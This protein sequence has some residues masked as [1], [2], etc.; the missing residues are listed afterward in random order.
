MPSFQSSS[1]QGMT[2]AHSGI[3]TCLCV[4]LKDQWIALQKYT[5][6]LREDFEHNLKLLDERDLELLER[7][8]ELEQLQLHYSEC[9]D[10]TKRLKQELFIAQQG[11]YFLFQMR[12]YSCV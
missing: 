5:D 11:M 7:E 10:Q 12:T 6:T 9:R 3:V 1:L 4:I 8:R 2:C